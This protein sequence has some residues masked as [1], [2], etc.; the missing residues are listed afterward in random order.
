MTQNTVTPRKVENQSAS[1]FSLDTWAVFLAL[2]LAL[3]IWIGVIKHVP[4]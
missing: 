4:W 1:R 3:L 2:G